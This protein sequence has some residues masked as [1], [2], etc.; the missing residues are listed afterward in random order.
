MFSQY[1]LK[2]QDT[3]HRL[4]SSFQEEMIVLSTLSTSN[5]IKQTLSMR[6]GGKE[7]IKKIINCLEKLKSNYNQK[8]ISPSLV[9]AVHMQ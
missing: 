4:L 6:Q 9:S 2:L 5:L 3:E 8:V 7:I 1:G